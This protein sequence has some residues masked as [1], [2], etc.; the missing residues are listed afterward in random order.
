[1]GGSIGSLVGL[2]I[3]GLSLIGCLPTPSV[4]GEA[5]TSDKWNGRGFMADKVFI[6][7]YLEYESFPGFSG[8]NKDTSD[9]SLIISSSC[10]SP[11]L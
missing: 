5:G 6:G 1:M 2:G 8:Q 9:L 11:K 7:S 4:G 10:V 3:F